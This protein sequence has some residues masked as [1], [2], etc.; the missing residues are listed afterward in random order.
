MHQGAPSSVVSCSIHAAH[1]RSAKTILVQGHAKSHIH[2]TAI[3]LSQFSDLASLPPAQVDG[4]LVLKDLNG[5]P[6]WSTGTS[7]KGVAPYQL[8]MQTSGVAHILD[9]A[10]TVIWA[11]KGRGLW[12]NLVEPAPCCGL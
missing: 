12:L 2:T 4:N 9:S 5:T 7:N 1:V 3:S 10:N 6:Y 11:S 8:V